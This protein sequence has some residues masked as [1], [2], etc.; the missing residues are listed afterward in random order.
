[1][2]GES[3]PKVARE[4]G[5]FTSNRRTNA[6]NKSDRDACHIAFLSA[7]IALQERARSEGGNAVVDIRLHHAPQRPRQRDG[8]PLRRGR[9]RGER[10]ADGARRRARWQEEVG[11]TPNAGV[12]GGSPSRCWSPRSPR[13][14]RSAR[15]LRAQPGALAPIVATEEIPGD[16]VLVQHLRVTRADQVQELDA[17]VQNACGELLVLPLSP[18][19]KP[20]F[21]IRQRGLSVAVD[22]A[23][24]AAPLPFEPER[25]LLDIERTYFVPLGAP[26]AR[27]RPPR[28]RVAR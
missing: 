2:K 6:F 23:V 22:A 20:A 26:A 28:G 16:F 27:R 17:V 5:T 18:F 7:V 3:H 24:P 13:A 11:A 25:V 4:L 9:R 14:R 19:G 15:A 8:L 21:V 1:M 10:G 12:R